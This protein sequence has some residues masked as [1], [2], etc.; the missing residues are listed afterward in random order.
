[1]WTEFLKRWREMVF[2]WLPQQ[3]DAA[4]QQD[5]ARREERST[6]GSASPEPPRVAAAE[7]P[8]SA[9]AAEQDDLTV[10]KG[11]GPAMQEKL[12][13]EGIH[14]FRDLAAAD[15]DALTARLKAVQ[16][17]ISRTRVEE[18]IKTARDHGR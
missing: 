4:P 13:A 12:R 7:R 18:W 1:M 11:I 8:E 17:V 14:S 6:T 10:I 5:Q 16:V 15:A 3:D 9:P 2:W